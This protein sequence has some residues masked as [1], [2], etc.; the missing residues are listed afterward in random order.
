[1]ITVRDNL[2][3]NMCLSLLYFIEITVLKW[4]HSQSVIREY[5]TAQTIKI[6]INNITKRKMTA[7]ERE[8]IS[9]YYSKDE[10]HVDRLLYDNHIHLL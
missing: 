3:G 9:K 2:P 7:R 8:S 10:S 6:D 4:C 5:S 1:M